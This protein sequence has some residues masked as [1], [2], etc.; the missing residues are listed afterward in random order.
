LEAH[1][2]SCDECRALLAENADRERLDRL[3]LGV[4]I[5]MN[6]PRRRPV[7]HI[8]RF[9][10]VPD[11]HARLLAATPSLSVS[12]LI[13]VAIALGFAVLASHNHASNPLPFLIVAPLLPLAGVAAAYSPGLDPTYEIG[14]A[15]PMRGGTLLLVRSTAVFAL[16]GV[17]VGLSSLGLPHLTWT[18]AAWLLPALGMAITS[19]ALATW[20]PPGWAAAVVG[21]VWVGGVLG[22]LVRSGTSRAEQLAWFK[23]AAQVGFC[24]VA[25]AA[26]AVALVRG[27][28]FESANHR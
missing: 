1:I 14:V 25:V 28:E 24:V 9:V 18:A 11:H 3:Y 4:R 15:S 10:G 8:L 12:W 2:V 26:A 23:P 22:T 21:T 5:G 6:E 27:D 19:L 7:E 13:A 20:I 17:L 16:T